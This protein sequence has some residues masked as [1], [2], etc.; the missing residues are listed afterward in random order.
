[1]GDLAPLSIAVLLL[2]AATLTGATKVFPRTLADLLSI[3]ASAVVSTVCLLLFFQALESPFVY[4]FGGWEPR[5][6][7]ALGISFSVD[8][9]GA[10]LASFTAILV[11]AALVYSWRYLNI[12]NSLFHALV[13]LFLA[14]MVGFCLTGDLFNSFVFFELMGVSAYGLTGY[15]I[16]ERRPLH[17][18]FNFAV[19]NSIGGLLLLTGIALVYGR[20][21]ALNLAQIGESLAGSRPDPLVI[22]AFVL[23][24]SGYFV[25]AAIVPFHFWLPDAHAVAPTPVCIIFSGTMVE[26]GLYAVARVY[27]TGFSASLQPEHYSLRATLLALG[28]VTAVGA[29]I[30]CFEQLHIKRLLAFSTVSHMGMFLVG[31]ALLDPHALAGIWVYFL[32]HGVV[33]AALFMGA[34]ILVHRFEQVGEIELRGRGRGL[35]GVGLLFVIGG[36]AIAGLPP[37]GTFLGKAVIEEAA[38]LRGYPWVSVL[39]LVASALT[40]GAV[41]RVAG[42]VFLGWSPP[43]AREEK[44]F[45]F[46]DEEV[47]EHHS[48]TV[49]P[50]DLTPWPMVVPMALFL[51]GGLAVGVWGGTLVE[52][53]HASEFFMDRVAYA[54]LVLGG[55]EPPAPSEAPP[56]HPLVASY[57]YAFG[58][59]AAALSLGVGALFRHRFPQSVRTWAQRVADPPVDRLRALHS[60]HVGDYVAW[61]VVGVAVLG[62]GLAPW[63]GV[64]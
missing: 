39:F 38:T 33:K 49:G 37:F 55:A 2:A 59:V 26:L 28:A 18:A 51:V 32:S 53:G 57:L 13:M 30:V 31:F 7:I 50:H 15:R 41:L 20:T 25:K 29:A 12:A 54:K 44:E 48:E 4:W 11:T 27:W 10:G 8:A 52:A 63:S 45:P 5:D 58:A 24:A 19:S 36:L 61:I 23:V 14:G 64:L 60:G 1:M 22:A 16:E 34:G 42:R 46:D 21:G 6:G 17:G 3:A 47:G 9:V 35:W 62:A 56:H 40:G 43:Y